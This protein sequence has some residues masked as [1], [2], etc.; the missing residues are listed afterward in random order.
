[1]LN[2]LYLLAK[3]IHRLLVVLIV[4]LGL[5]MSFTGTVM[6]FPNLSEFMGVD[7][8]SMRSLHNFIS[9]Y[10][11]VIFLLMMFTGVYLFLFPYLKKRGS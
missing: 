10:F 11:V 5:I 8:V 9:A 4:G 3:S 6:K 1:M 7:L 2:K